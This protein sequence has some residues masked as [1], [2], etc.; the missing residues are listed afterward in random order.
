MINVY[1][2]LLN[3]LYRLGISVQFF[4]RQ[5]MDKKA[6]DEAHQGLIARIKVARELNENDL[7]KI[8]Q[9]RENPLLL[10]LDGITDP[11]NLGA[12]LR[13]DAAGVC[14]A[15]NFKDK[16]AAVLTSTVRKVACGAAETVPL[17]KVTNLAR[18]LRD[19]QSQFNIWVVGT[20]GEATE[21][22]YVKV[23]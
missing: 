22:I 3:E 14:A 9:D 7:A 19:L 5:T 17:I 13:T 23:D 1:N 8:L 4:N 21:T 12:Y 11:H 2:P 6:Q 20:A 16:S 18:T 10:V 15:L